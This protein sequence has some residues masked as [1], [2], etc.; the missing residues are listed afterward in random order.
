MKKKKSLAYFTIPA[1]A[2]ALFVLLHLTTPFHALDRRVYDQLLHL[3][4]AV[5]EN[6]AILFL[7]V[8]DLAISRV[9]TWPWGRDRM[10]DGLLLLREFGAAHAVFDIEYTDK[11]P[12][13][14]NA[15][16]LNDE[17]PSAVKEEFATVNQNIKDLFTALK[18]KQISLNE[19]STYIADLE[20]L[21]ENSKKILLDRIHAIARN[22]DEY[23]GK[24]A[25]VFGN[26]IFTVNMLP[27]P[28]KETPLD[29]KQKA[30]D[31]WSLKKISVDKSYPNHVVDIR[32]SIWPILSR[33]A[34]AGFPNVIIDDD[35][36][37]RRITLTQSYNGKFFPQLGFAALLRWF[38]NPELV[39]TKDELTI[40]QALLPDGVKKDIRIPLDEESRM[41]I[42][43]PKKTFISSFRHLS[44]YELVLHKEIETNLFH[45]L[46]AM[47]DA[48][49]LSYFPGG[50]A[51]MADYQKAEAMRKNAVDAEKSE[52]MNGYKE[53][54][55]G[56]FSRASA[57]LK[58]DAEKKI[59]AEIDAAIA[60]GKLTDDQK[61]EYTSI[62]TDVAKIFEAS[63]GLSDEF[64][65]LRVRLQKEL[66]GSY[67]LIG[68]TGTS[69]TD[70]G[71]NPFEKEYMNV[72]THASVVNTILSGQF[73]DELPWWVSQIAGAVIAFILTLLLRNMN[74]LASLVTG[75][76]AVVV[77]MIAGTAF[78]IATGMY[79]P[80]LAPVL[81]VFFTFLALAVVKFLSTEQEK[82]FYRTAFSHYLSADVIND[83]VANPDKLSLGGEKKLLTAV[84][85]DVK[86]FSSVSEVLDASDLVK[87]LNLY[88]T[89]MSDIILDLHGTID[90]Y[91]GDAII[92]FFGAPMDLEDH[93]RRACLAAIRMKRVE[94]ILNKKFIDEKL[95]PNAL[96]TRIG[97]NTGE[98]VVGNMGTLKKMDYTIMG[99][100][101][102]L[103]AR[104]EAHTKEAGR[105]ILIDAATQ[106]ALGAGFATENLGPVTF[107]GKAAAVD[108]FA[109]G[110]TGT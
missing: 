61:K 94:K 34:G 73:L 24:A 11:S 3:R 50:D 23:L 31:T 9:G 16:V 78:F 86:G 107:K 58:S 32:P 70:I 43:W 26:A 65:K 12:L 60:T 59:T 102:N 45:N 52:L 37:R 101:V 57:F 97:V 96:L 14:V 25:A 105:S 17:I 99:N 38:G 109:L 66:A 30:V 68:N 84:F 18:Q 56:I 82:T 104:L 42:N 106:A 85:T 103:A 55:D 40:K 87:L 71:V 2:A 35:G 41:V 44:F 88:L 39:V 64:A 6:P 8:D 28:D 1:V 49:Y 75:L 47:A 51:M 72:G 89:E 22:N 110:G 4:P 21:T 13:G 81:T 19:A 93:A 63:R 10:A 79:L 15:E 91:E 27:E 83:L 29:L 92:S 108:C 46:K 90:K 54:R 48:G 76:V 74:P 80:L 69:T 77:M 36:V 98:M 53:L 95:S 7:D 62:K 5:G 20:N 67:C 33:G 100:S